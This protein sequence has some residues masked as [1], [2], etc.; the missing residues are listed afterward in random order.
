MTWIKIESG[1]SQ[2]LHQKIKLGLDKLMRLKLVNIIHSVH[3]VWN[4]QQ[5]AKLRIPASLNPT[6]PISTVYTCLHKSYHTSKILSTHSETHRIAHKCLWFGR[7]RRS[8]RIGTSGNDANHFT[9]ITTDSSLK[10]V[11]TAVGKN[12]K[13]LMRFVLN[14]VA[15]HNVFTFIS[16]D[17]THRTSLPITWSWLHSTPYLQP[18]LSPTTINLCCAVCYSLPVAAPRSPV[19]VSQ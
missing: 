19:S 6:S 10:Y 5:I 4:L 1:S 8:A 7:R 15:H 14:C 17:A 11:P 9:R 3:K 13:H 12:I 16:H 2:T 18:P